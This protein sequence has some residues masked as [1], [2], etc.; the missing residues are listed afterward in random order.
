VIF[1]YR[2][3]LLL[4]RAKALQKHLLNRAPELRVCAE[5]AQV[6]GVLEGAQADVNGTLL[7]VVVD[8]AVPRG[9]AWIEAGHDGTGS[10]PP[11]GAALNIKAVTA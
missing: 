10:L 4:R 8:A 11:Y 7:P 5:D 1:S 3:L 9:C 2:R 6:L